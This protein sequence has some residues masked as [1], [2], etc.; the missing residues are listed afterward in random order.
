[1][2]MRKIISLLFLAVFSLLP[3]LAENVNSDYRVKLEKAGTLIDSVGIGNVANVKSLTVEGPING[4]D[5][6]FIKRLSNV[7]VLDLGG[8][9]IVAGGSGNTYITED[10][11]I[12]SEVFREYQYLQKLI[13]PASV[14]QMESYSVV[15][16]QALTELVLPDSLREMEYS[17]IY[18]CNVLPKIIIPGSVTRLPHSVIDYCSSLH[19]IY[20]EENDFD[21]GLELTVRNFKDLPALDTLYVGRNIS[22]DF[23]YSRPFE[24]ADFSK[25][26]IGEKVTKIPPYL[27]RALTKLKEVDIH[28]QLEEIGGLAFQSCLSLTTVNLPS[29]LKIIGP[30]AFEYCENLKN[31]TL[32]DK[33]ENIGSRAFAKCKSL[34]KI[35]LSGS[36]AVMGDEVFSECT[37]LTSAVLK[38]GLTTIPDFT[39]SRCSNLGS[40]TFPKTL[41][42]IG[43]NAFE[44]CFKITTLNFPE[45][46]ESIGRYAFEQCTG[47]TTLTFPAAITTISE[48]S[49]MKCSNLVDI[50][51][52]KSL[53]E[54]EDY[55]FHQASKLKEVTFPETLTKIGHLAFGGAV[56]LRT[57]NSRA[58]TPPVATNAFFDINFADAVLYVPQGTK[59]DYWLSTEWGKFVNIEEKDFTVSN[60]AI[61]PESYRIYGGHQSVI[62]ETDKPLTVS[63]YS[64]TGKLVR[65]TKA[66]V[67]ITTI[68]VPSNSIYIVT[69]DGKTK[70]IIVNQ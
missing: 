41:K 24:N 33:L 26:I 70:K 65:T 3:L 64:I 51:F 14:R 10:N 11:T 46:L 23:E 28:S 18:N 59:N 6:A 17:T 12:G 7:V 50:K 8:A 9:D 20:L 38:E 5:I 63:V 45:G 61:Q 47:V 15:S 57:V 22:G 13:L 54:I 19:T 32:P 25:L 29:S 43:G 56:A 39:F 58:T 16:N 34:T 60:E 40:V 30:S 36:L 53:T 27:F 66:S 48:G 49:F 52:S 67:G 2:N 62:V 1:M 4:I 42:E 44:K 68:E 21:L 55:A 35:E 37:A 69:A 31:I